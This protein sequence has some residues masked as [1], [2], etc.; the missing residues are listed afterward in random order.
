MP[1]HLVFCGTY[2]D[3]SLQ[4]GG[5]PAGDRSAIGVPEL[6]GSDGIH[7]FE[8]D[9]D[10]GGLRPIHT[11]EGVVNPSYLALDDSERFLFAVNETR[12]LDGEPTGAVSSFAIDPETGMPSFVSQQP[13]GGGNPCHLSVSRC[14]RYLLVANHEAAT[15]AVLPIDAQGGLS[16]PVDVRT[17]EPTD[18]TGQRPP[19]AHFVAP[20]PGGAFVV[21]TDTGTDRIMSYRLDAEHGRLIPNDPPWGETH[22]GGSP[23]H[24]DFHP[25]GRFVYANGEADLTLSVFRYDPAGGTLDHIQHVPTVPDGID[26]REFSTAQIVAHPSG[27][28]VYVSNRGHNS[29]AVFQVDGATGMV[30]RIAVESTRGHIPRNFMIDPSGRF[31]YV[32]NQDSGTIECFSIDQQSGLLTHSTRAA[33]VPAPTCILFTTT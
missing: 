27:S 26:T 24:L 31:L 17:D 18:P 7:V 14:G 11:V 28:F 30:T 20:D 16:P 4:G 5:D 2:T 32:A 23:R 33:E 29:I 3:L 9:P 19:H 13:S 6:T 12:E 10:S 21:S 15:I 22:P 25:A 8:H 1:R